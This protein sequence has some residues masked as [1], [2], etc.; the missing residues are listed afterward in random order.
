MDKKGFGV[1]A[2]SGGDARIYDFSVLKKSFKIQKIEEDEVVIP[3][4]QLPQIIDQGSFQSC[5]ACSLAALLE[6]FEGLE[7][8]EQ[9]RFSHSYIYGKHRDKSSTNSGMF[10]ETALKSM[11]NCGSVPLSVWSRPMEMPEAKTMVRD[12][13]E[14]EKLAIPSRIGGYCK[15]RWGNDQEAVEN[16]Y[17]AIKN[18]GVPVVATSYHAFGEHHCILIY[19]ANVKTREVYVQN[20]WGESWGDKG[21]CKM[22]VGNF[23]NAWMVMDEVAALPFKDVSEDA[24][25]YKAIANMYRA[26]YLNGKSEDTFDPE[27]YVKRGE[28]AQVL[29]KVLKRL[30]EIDDARTLC[31]EGWIKDVEDRISGN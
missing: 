19:G 30:D 21:R 18:T 27:G 23:E 7:K 2:G 31:I 16:I 26:G 12:N 5:V 28:L 24:W 3:V 10:V 15:I 14:L 9:S 6:F 22:K 11:L 17:L 1:G 13:E 29:N 4:E 25:Y 20:S 8:G